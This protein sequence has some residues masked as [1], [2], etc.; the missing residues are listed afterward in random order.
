M[1]KFRSGNLCIL[2]NIG[3]NEKYPYIL[4][5]VKG[6]VKDE[7]LRVVI[8]STDMPGF[9]S[10]VDEER[11]SSATL[12]NVY[13]T[14]EDF[15]GNQD[16]DVFDKRARLLFHGDLESITGMLGQEWFDSYVLNLDMVRGIIELDIDMF[17]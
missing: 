16:W 3:Y 10:E 6:Y 14:I 4:V 13:N 8:Q 15:S 2:E 1:E 12:R 17:D 5:T 9:Y 11:L 7:P